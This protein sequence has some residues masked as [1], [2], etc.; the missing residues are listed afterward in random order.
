MALV[1]GALAPDAI[2]RVSSKDEFFEQYEEYNDGNFGAVICEVES[3]EF[4]NEVGQVLRNQCPRTPAFACALSRDKF[5]PKLLKKNGF[6]D[7]FFLPL[8]RAE[9]VEQLASATSGEALK[10]RALKRIL[11]PDL[12]AGSAPTFTTFVHLPLNNKHLVFSAKDETLS[13]RKVSKL[14]ERQVGNLFIDQKEAGAF[15]DYV[16]EQMHA[17]DNTLSATERQDKLKESVRG[18]FGEVFDTRGEATFDSGRELLDSCRKL[19][20]AYVMNGS[21]K[22]DFH[23]RLLRNLNGSGLEYSHAADVST[24]AALFGMA[25]GSP[26][27]EALAIAGFLHDVSLA[28]FPEPHGYGI[29]PAWTD[30]VKKMYVEHPMQSV[31]LIKM[32][33]MIMA[34]EAEKMI[35]QHHERFDGKGFP[36]GLS[37]DRIL[38]ESQILS[39]A[40]Q[41]QYL[42]ISEPGQRRLNPLEAVA[43]IEANGSLDPALI[44]AVR[45]LLSPKA[46]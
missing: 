6:T 33:K 28:S 11:T 25:L 3:S 39:L 1:E 2:H 38:R 42:T 14:K 34:P 5:E 29:N 13:D 35:L 4:A 12:Q 43:S 27:I 44:R 21:D 9:F 40:D 30:E 26:L 18:I 23:S 7:A 32:R 36:R 24:M 17:G 8:D 15:F 20:S 37:G 19:V 16:A 10:R 45:E 31:N 41:F 22:G 46:S